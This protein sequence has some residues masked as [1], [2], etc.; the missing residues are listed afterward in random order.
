MLLLPLLLQ[1]RFK[2]AQM[3]N[4]SDSISPLNHFIFFGH[5]YSCLLLIGLPLGDALVVFL[6]DSMAYLIIGLPLGRYLFSYIYPKY[7]IIFPHFNKELFLRQSPEEQR[8]TLN[9]L[10]EFPYARSFYLAI[11][12]MIKILPAGI[13]L[14][15]FCHHDLPGN[16]MWPYFISLALFASP[17]YSSFAFIELHTLIT[18]RVY[19]LHRDHDLG[20]TFQL[21]ENPQ[22]VKRFFLREHLALMFC[23]LI[24]VTQIWVFLI[25]EQTMQWEKILWPLGTGLLVLS[26]IYTLHRDYLVK[27]TQKLEQVYHDIGRKKNNYIALASSPLLSK[28]QS[29]FNKLISKLKKYEEGILM[30]IIKETEQSRFRAIGEI[31]AAVGHSLKGPIHAIYFSLDEIEEGDIQDKKVAK[32]L[33][34]I[35]ENIKRVEELSNSLNASLRSPDGLKYTYIPLAHEEVINL[36]KHEFAGIEDVRF[37]LLGF[38][39]LKKRIS[40]SQR[41]IIHIL[42]N[43]YKNSLKN[44]KDHDISSP[45][46]TLEF[47]EATDSFVS[48]KCS[49]NGTGLSK[50]GFESF[51]T[52]NFESMTA[53]SFKEGLGLR[54][55]KQLLENNGGTLTYLEPPPEG[56]TSFTLSFPTAKT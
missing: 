39:H 23:F 17:L 14:I 43:L 48:L 42:Y 46:I 35:R 25:V 13:T 10:Y 37:Q 54:L 50:G 27:G 3:K 9:K 29:T 52:I 41:D 6:V 19:D 21:Y 22:S 4:L 15:Y 1:N 18:K 7:R 20:R 30:W 16:I 45:Q 31:S 38:D 53:K 28:F 11:S 12:N 40:I 55:T 32:Y 8:E 56:G 47:L 2:K 26:R 49:D 33:K 34:Y 36:L 24:F 5:I 44:F 51:T